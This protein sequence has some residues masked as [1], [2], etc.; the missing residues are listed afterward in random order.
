MI[1]Y[2]LTTNI[3][4][5]IVRLTN[6]YKVQIRFNRVLL[7]VT[8]QTVACQSPLSMGFYRPEYWHGLPFPPPGDLPDQEIDP[9]S[10]VFPSLASRFFNRWATL[11]ALRMLLLLF[12]H[13]VVSNTL[14][15]HGLQ[16]V[17]HLCPSSSPGACPSLCPLNWWCHSIISSS[18]TLF[19]FCP[20]SF[21]VSGC[22]PVSQLFTSGG[23]SIGASASVSVLRVNIQDWYPLGLTGLI[24][25]QSLKNVLQHHSSKA[26]I[27]WHSAF[28]IVQL[29][30]IH[31]CI[32]IYVYIWSMYAHAFCYFNNIYCSYTHNVL[33]YWNF[34]N[35]EHRGR[36]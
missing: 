24:Y 32:H 36:G 30:C 11:E 21:P 22:F 20:Q 10:P 5:I 28:F 19:S 31:T 17:G 27:L 2:I 33:I 8:P 9:E 26:S 7:F 4:V 14:W 3:I 6:T 29:S 25:L 13:Q 16:F 1:I 34:N 18:D 12:S 35:I 15:P 23:Q